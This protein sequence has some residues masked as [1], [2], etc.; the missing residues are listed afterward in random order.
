MSNKYKEEI[1]KQ[2]E[3][4]VAEYSILSYDEKVK[5]MN[6]L[7]EWYMRE[8]DNLY[9][10]KN[11]YKERKSYKSIRGCHIRDLREGEWIENYKFLKDNSVSYP[12]FL[13]KLL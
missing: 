3:N 5:Y 10:K 12:K 11:K 2:F 7:T 9:L 13:T 8:K 1:Y 6:N 4:M